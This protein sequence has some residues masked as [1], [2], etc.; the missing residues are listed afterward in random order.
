MR[1]LGAVAHFAQLVAVYQQGGDPADHRLHQEGECRCFVEHIAHTE[2][3][4]HKNDEEKVQG[5]DSFYVE[6]SHFRQ[7]EE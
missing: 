6:Q 5:S 2:R 7:H 3:S 4:G 1:N